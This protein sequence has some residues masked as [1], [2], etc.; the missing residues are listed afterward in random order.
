MD[1]AE[2]NNY[3]FICFTKEGK[4]LM[5]RVISL[6]PG[7]IADPG[8][9]KLPSGALT[10]WTGDNFVTGNILVF[11]G[12][13]G[14]AVRAIAPFVSD[15][16]RDAAVIVIDEKGRF[17]IPVLSGH[18]G[19]AIK[20]AEEIAD[21]IGGAPVIT[22][23]TDVRGEFAVD[24][25]AKENDLCISDMKKAK[26]FS[27]YLL[28]NKKAYYRIDPEYA[29]VL[30]VSIKKKNVTEGLGDDEGSFTIS[31]RVGAFK[32]LQL[33]PKCIVIGIGCRKGK[34]ASELTEF[35]LRTLKELALDERSVTAVTSIDLKKGEKGI[36]ELSKRLSAGFYTYSKEV[37]MR[38]KG[39][40]TTSDF[41]REKVGADNVCERSLMA[42]GCE[43][44]IMKKRAENGMTLAIGAIRRESGYE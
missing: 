17:V 10:E 39:D 28:E 40:F 1:L 23:A 19:G 16:T 2:K 41:V 4:E 22:T 11:I 43:R 38:Q 18:L 15:K 21:L 13:L 35:V 20:A 24:V 31:P 32:N 30:C 37:L 29:D 5:S 7:D 14:I 34:P 12:A 9:K 6:L 8:F 26:A 33:I 44:I 27:A 3:K 25:F 42:F 36:L